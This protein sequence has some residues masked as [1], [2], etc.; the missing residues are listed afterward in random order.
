MDHASSI[1]RK[2]TNNHIGPSGGRCGGHVAFTIP[3][4][5]GDVQIIHTPLEEKPESGIPGQ[6]TPPASG[7]Q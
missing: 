6:G 1:F 2:C 7:P 4:C 5:P 3:N